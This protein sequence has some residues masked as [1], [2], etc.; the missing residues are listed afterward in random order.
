MDDKSKFTK[1][2]KSYS[3]KFMRKVNWVSENIEL[4][5]QHLNGLDIP[6]R[7]I[8]SIRPY[9]VTFFPTIAKGLIDEHECIDFI[10]YFESSL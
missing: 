6:V 5:K 9:M 7:K 3:A 4:I 10:E 8:E 1:G 2:N